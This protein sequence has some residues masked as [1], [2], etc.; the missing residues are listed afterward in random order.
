[1]F[2]SISGRGPQG[3]PHLLGIDSEQK[4]FYSM[5]RCVLAETLIKDISKTVHRVFFYNDVD[6]VDWNELPPVRRPM[7]SSGIQNLFFPHNSTDA[8][9]WN[10]HHAV[11][12]MGIPLRHQRSYTGV[13]VRMGSGGPIGE[14]HPEG[15]YHCRGMELYPD[16]K[17]YLR[18]PF[19]SA[20]CIK[21]TFE[22]DYE[23]D[24]GMM[25]MISGVEN[26]VPERLISPLDWHDSVR[27]DIAQEGHPHIISL[28]MRFVES[29]HPDP[30]VPH[31]TRVAVFSIKE[32]ALLD[33]DNT[34][35]NGR[36]VHNYHYHIKL[37][38][39]QGWDSKEKS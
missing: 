12:G 15:I 4:P 34:T 32:I 24:N 2:E 19:G 7:W 11:I 16:L 6:A 27:V 28:N 3:E 10:H 20:T 22:I 33:T 14:W 17:S 39:Y 1:M 26:V 25:M 9:A 37:R 29:Q 23:D 31:M 30:D 21:L 35:I 36:R 5:S 38:H 13:E 8:Y 18:V